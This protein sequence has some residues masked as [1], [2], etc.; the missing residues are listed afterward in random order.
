MRPFAAGEIQ[1]GEAG[2]AD[3]DQKVTAE[4]LWV[5]RFS[6]P[7]RRKRTFRV[8]CQG[9][10]DLRNGRTPSGNH[11]IAGR[12]HTSVQVNS[13]EKRAVTAMFTRSAAR[14]ERVEGGGLQFGG[15]E[16]I[17]G[18]G[19]SGER[20]GAGAFGGCEGGELR[21]RLAALGDAIAE[22]A[23]YVALGQGVAGLVI[24]EH[25]WLGLEPGCR[26]RCCE[27]GQQRGRRRA[28]RDACARRGG[29]GRPGCAAPALAVE[30]SE[31]RGEGAL[32]GRQR[33]DQGYEGGQVRRLRK[34][35]ESGRAGADWCAGLEVSRA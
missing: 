17:R 34:R 5:E 11:R 1:D 10:E 2:P 4:G 23:P 16:L 35:W 13:M 32:G 25:F 8:G 7:A 3:E 26:G 19:R 33:C 28:R 6:S 30:V 27:S 14:E 15:G 22:G 18:G 9:G 29:S 20:G 12:P 21:G 31:A 24:G